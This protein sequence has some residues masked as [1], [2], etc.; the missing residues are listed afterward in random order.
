MIH[1]AP[2]PVTI[3]Q[4]NVEYAIGIPAQVFLALI[5]RPWFPVRVGKIGNLRVVDRVAFVTWLVRA[6]S[7]TLSKKNDKRP[8][9]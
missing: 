1:A 9:P 5:R 6:A 3:T 2:L 8:K 4:H 7:T